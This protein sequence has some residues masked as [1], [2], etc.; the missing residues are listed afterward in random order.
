MS[1]PLCSQPPP[2]TRPA[3]S[4]GP[5]APVSSLL[6]RLLLYSTP[7]NRFLFYVPG[8]PSPS[9]WPHTCCVF[10]RAS[11]RQNLKQIHQ[12]LKLPVLPVA[13]MCP[14]ISVSFPVHVVMP[15]PSHAPV[16]T[17]ERLSMGGLVDSTAPLRVYVGCCLYYFHVGC[18]EPY[19]SS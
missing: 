5:A 15:T 18:H 10:H 11:K 4:P 19:L 12:L 16:G 7:R 14:W 1:T 13:P 9:A 17:D 2:R 3:L 8:A 6:Q